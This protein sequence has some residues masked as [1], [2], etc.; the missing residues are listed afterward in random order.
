MTVSSTGRRRSTGNLPA[1]TQ[2]LV[3]TRT[4]LLIVLAVAAGAVAVAFP[5]WGQAI[6]AGFTALLAL[7]TLTGK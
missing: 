7:H 2:P 6:A 3:S 4:L 5:Q 1:S